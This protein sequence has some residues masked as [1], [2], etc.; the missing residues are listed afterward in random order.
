MPIWPHARKILLNVE[1]GD[2][3]TMTSRR[4]GCPLEALGWTEH[5]GEIRSFEKLK[6]DGRL[7]YGAQLYAL[8]EETLPSRFG[9][10]P[11]DYQLLEEETPDGH[12]AVSVIVHPRLGPLDEPALLDALHEALEAI[13]ASGTGMARGTVRVRRVPPMLTKVGKFM[14]V[15]YLTRERAG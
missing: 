14:P 10:G 9:D 3:A 11:A 2:C 15:R 5:L 7:F 1:T 4:C 6:I 8:I 13:S 12:T